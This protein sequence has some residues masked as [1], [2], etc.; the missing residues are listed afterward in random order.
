MIAVRAESGCRITDVPGLPGR[1]D[2]IPLPTAVITAESPSSGQLTYL[3][4]PPLGRADGRTE[5]EAVDWQLYTSTTVTVYRPTVR[6]VIVDGPV[7][8]CCTTPLDQINVHGPLVPVGV[9]VAVPSLRLHVAPVV[10]SVGGQQAPTLYA[11]TEGSL[12]QAGLFHEPDSPS[13]EVEKLTVRS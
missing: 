8:P 5:S 11:L 1:A 9:A 2:H 4:P 13:P 3:I 7:T 10:V 12:L 6:P